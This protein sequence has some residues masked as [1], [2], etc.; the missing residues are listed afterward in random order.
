M[1]TRWWKDERK[2][3]DEYAAVNTHDE[4]PDLKFAHNYVL[5]L[6]GLSSRACPLYLYLHPALG[7]S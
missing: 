7:S 5:G 4:S 1:V 2:C 3:D 6:F